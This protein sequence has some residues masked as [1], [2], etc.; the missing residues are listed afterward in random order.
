MSGYGH[1]RTFL[2]LA[3]TSA[4]GGKTDI[5]QRVTF[6]L[7]GILAL[8]RINRCASPVTFI[9]AVPLYGHLRKALAH[10]LKRSC[11]KLGE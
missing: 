1:K 3:A 2:K 4:F 11:E 5:R 7:S 6:L 8:I 10:H 9:R